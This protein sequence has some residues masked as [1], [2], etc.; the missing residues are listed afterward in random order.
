MSAAT[1][2]KV[3]NA[4]SSEQAIRRG[5]LA[6]VNC[7]HPHAIICHAHQ[8]SC[9]TC[10][11][12]ASTTMHSSSLQISRC[13]LWHAARICTHRTMSN[14]S[15]FSAEGKCSKCDYIDLS[16]GLERRKA[17]LRTALVATVTPNTRQTVSARIA[18]PVTQVFGPSKVG[19]CGYCGEPQPMTKEHV[20]PQKYGGD[21][22][23]GN[24]IYACGPCNNDRGH[25]RL[26][27]WCRQLKDAGDQRYKRVKAL[28]KAIKADS[29]QENRTALDYQTPMVLRDA[30]AGVG[31]R[32][33]LV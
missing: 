11:L 4:K 10:G 13:R 17:A 23:A 33:G 8:S 22:S 29:Q 1:C 9:K 3:Q 21:D 20:K 30:R 28:R 25:L 27:D 24:M 14:K 18:K 2:S 6:Q 31:G 16:I 26:T 7:R 32:A 5:W 15:A 19:I 12:G